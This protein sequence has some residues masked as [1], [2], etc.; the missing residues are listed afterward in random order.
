MR[1]ED[2]SGFC[3][4][5]GGRIYYE[6]AGAGP[7]VLMIHAGVANLRMWDG[8]VTALR[9]RLRF[10]RFDTRGFGRTISE[11]VEFSNRRDALAVLD[12]AGE[13]SAHVVGLSRGGQI[14]LDLA[15]E[16]QGCV[17]SLMVAAGGVSG[18]QPT[19]ESAVDWDEVESWEEAKDW[20]R[21]TA[22]ET[23]HWFDGPG[24][25]ADRGNSA[26]RAM[27]A[28]WIRSNYAAEPEYGIPRPLDP[29]ASQRLEELAAPLLV[30]VGEFDD[31]GTIE[32]MHHLAAAVPCSRIESLTAAHM[33]NLEQV[34]R[35]NELLADHVEAA[36]G[37]QRR[38]DEVSQIRRRSP[39]RRRE[40][41][42]T[43]PIGSACGVVR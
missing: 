7:P 39:T 3:E 27:V 24:H 17:R 41:E 19:V 31:P 32:A 43:P 14:A 28:E 16:H 2:I 6:V 25:P 34:D 33:I 15:I 30:L 10:I 4:V 21:L 37:Q 26:A 1:S 38:A 29:P 35:F 42:R 20:D 12:A 8:Q 13:T 23:S 11:H 22:F 5:D 40:S 36:E 9:H 18:F